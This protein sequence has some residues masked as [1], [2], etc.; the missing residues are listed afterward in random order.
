MCA[1]GKGPKLCPECGAAPCYSL[2]SRSPDYYSAEQER[3]DSEYHDSLS[4][5]QWFR[6]AVMQY[7]MVH[8][9]PYVS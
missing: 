6:L 9:E 1:T 8:G 5:D 3:A 7:E 2:C 4:H